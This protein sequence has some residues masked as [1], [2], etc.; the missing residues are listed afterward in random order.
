MLLNREK[1]H[2]FNNSNTG[3]LVLGSITNR[4]VIERS[5]VFDWQ[6]F[7]V[8][9]I[10]FDWVRQ[11]NDWCS[12]G[13]DCRTVRLD[14]SGG[15]DLSWLPDKLS[16]NNIIIT[17]FINCVVS[18]SI[19]TS[20]AV[21]WRARRTS[22]NT[23][24]EYSRRYYTAKCTFIIQHAKLLCPCGRISRTSIYGDCVTEVCETERNWRGK[25]QLTKWWNFTVA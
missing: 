13:F 21:F 8:S 25:I 19:F 1:S 2:H 7:I 10:M 9:S 5:I 11:S 16:F 22:Q 6:N 15:L 4:S 24:N 23:N 17:R 12:I 14:R 20:C 18:L 3:S